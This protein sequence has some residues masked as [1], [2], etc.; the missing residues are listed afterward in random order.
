[1]GILFLA[2]SWDK[3]LDPK[4][5]AVIIQNYKILPAV[6]VQPFA[7]FLPWIEAICGI[8]LVSGKLTKGAA[9]IVAMLMMIFIIALTLNLYR[10]LDI[11]CG[12]FSLSTESKKSAYL[13][14]IRDFGILCTG[15]WVLFFKIQSDKIL[16]LYTTSR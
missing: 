10:G 13:Y 12:C 3:I 16:S 6:L 9:L 4:G 8:L 2:A 14:L 15:L 11:S 7:L 1:M 5:F